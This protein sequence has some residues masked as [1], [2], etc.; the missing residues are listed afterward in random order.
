[1]TTNASTDEK[2]LKASEKIWGKSVIG[3]G[4]TI[5][6]SL[7]LKSQNRLGIK[8]TE[9]AVILQIALHWW[10]HDKKPFPSKQALSDR[11]G[12]S[13]RQ[14]QRIIAR[15]EEEKLIN[16]VERFAQNHGRTS[17]IYDLTG[18]VEKLKQ[19]EPEFKKADEDAKRKLRNV[20]RPKSKNTSLKGE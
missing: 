17:N 14:V 11:L 12:I 13:P 7:L 3:L 2:E 16:R 1:M 15:L 10:E 6:P 8:P 4:Y 5:I 19:L 20:A 9:L 18:L